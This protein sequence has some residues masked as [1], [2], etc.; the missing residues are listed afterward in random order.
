MNKKPVTILIVE[1]EAMTAIYM[2]TML[3]K[4]GFNV[5]D[6]VSSGEEAYDFIIGK[7]PDLVIMDIQLAGMINGIETVRKVK[8]MLSDEVQFVFATGYS[9]SELKELA[10]QYNPL[11]YFI[12]PVK[13]TELVDIIK[14][15][16]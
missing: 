3:E 13:I 7:T 16:F 10:M 8:N 4:N 1:D 11:A 5:L 12:K 15:Y 14:Q 6:C 9:D 2:R